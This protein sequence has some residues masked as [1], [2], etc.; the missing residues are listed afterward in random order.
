[1]HIT[2]KCQKLVPLKKEVSKS[3]I[4]VGDFNT[5]LSAVK[6]SSKLVISKDI[7]ISKDLNIII[8][9]L[10]RICYPTTENTFNHIHTDRL[11]ETTFW[12]IKHS[13]ENLKEEKLM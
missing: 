11:R 2:T 9:Q 12:A 4:V 5:S 10:D 6:K 13:L 7:K 1:M 3:T 8:N